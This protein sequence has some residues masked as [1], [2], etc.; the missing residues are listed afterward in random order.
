MSDLED[1][2]NSDPND[3]RFYLGKFGADDVQETD[4]SMQEHEI[5]M[6]INSEYADNFNEQKL[7]T[8]IVMPA[9][10]TKCLEYDESVLSQIICIQCNRKFANKYTL[11][12]HLKICTEFK[13]EIVCIFAG[14]LFKTDNIVAFNQHKI[15]HQEANFACL[16]CG[17]RFKSNIL[18]VYHELKHA[19]AEFKCEICNI[20]YKYKSNFNHHNR[21]KHPKY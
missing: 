20:F 4:L 1:M 12:T 17:K 7:R 9:I 2:R 11:K 13:R 15:T 21:K 18:L 5:N 3:L 19:P 14:C 8:N 6:M 10:E 16:K